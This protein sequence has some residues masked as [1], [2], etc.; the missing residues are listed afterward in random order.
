VVWWAKRHPQSVG[1]STPVAAS[2][3]LADVHDAQ[4]KEI[5]LKKKDG[6]TVDLQRQNGKWAITAPEPLPADQDA[7]SSLVS[8][9]SP[10]TA[11]SVV[12]DKPADLSKY[13]LKDPS[14]TVTIDEKN[15]KTDK[16]FFGDDVPAG[17]L[18]YVR[19]GSDP[20][21]YAVSSSTKTSLDKTAK[22]LRYKRLLTFDQN[23]LTLIELASG[24]SYI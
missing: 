19:V 20:K 11:D 16:I 7:V 8:S 6:T 9:L 13:G 17:S 12:D 18:A 14:L 23:Q 21:V 2:P 15:G 4:I 1:P 5:D 24:K 3:K 22:D 10:I